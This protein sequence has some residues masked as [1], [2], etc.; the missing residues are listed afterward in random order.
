MR[1]AGREGRG[2][3]TVSLEEGFAQDHVVIRLDGDR[4]YDE[5]DV[6]TRLQT[7]LAA[8]VRLEAAAACRLEVSLPGR[9]LSH[10]LAVDATRTPYVQVSVVGDDVQVHAAE[11]PP[12]YA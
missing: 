9:G 12:Y 3:L 10:Q 4:A 1:G 11:Q 5:R 7:G 6:T 8:A 2:V